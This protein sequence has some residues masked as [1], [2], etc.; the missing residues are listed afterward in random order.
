VLQLA[1]A[2]AAIV[3]FARVSPAIQ[4]I[5]EENVA[6]LSAVQRM[7]QALAS[8]APDR[9]G[10]FAA[11]L[12]LA[13][14]NVTEPEER[15]LLRQVRAEQGAALG[16]DVRAMRATLVALEQLAAA[17]LAAMRRA[18]HRARRIGEAGAWAM[19]VLGMLCFLVSIVAARKVASHITRPLMRIH[20][21]VTAVRRGDARR[22]CTIDDAAPEIGDIARTV[23]E[24][25]DAAG[26]PAARPPRAADPASPEHLRGAL[27][28]LLDEQPGPA[29]VLSETG[30]VLAAN[31]PALDRL[32]RETGFRERLLT[33]STGTNDGPPSEG[34]PPDVRPAGPGVWLVRLPADAAPGTFSAPANTR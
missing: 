29:L 26:A 22:R 7:Q 19:A 2:G 8:A 15:P 3:L 34:P 6:S 13:E 14:R 25:L 30:E 18:D 10:A 1:T 27:L 21:T 32:G 20:D 16:G 5:L 33:S 4:Q 11:A 17:N 23:D 28:A 12:A 31:A 24:L 9:A